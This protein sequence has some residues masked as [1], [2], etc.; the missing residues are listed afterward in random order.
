MVARIKCRYIVKSQT[1]YWLVIFLV[2]LN[3]LT[4]ASEHNDQP[5]WLTKAQGKFSF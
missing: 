4:F 1:F 2:F 5:M 3:T